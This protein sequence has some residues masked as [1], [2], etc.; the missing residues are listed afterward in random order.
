M[1]PDRRTGR[2]SDILGHRVYDDIGEPIGRI[3]DL[4]TEG[5]PDGTHRVTAAIVV[6]HHWGRL[7]GYERREVTGPW[8]LEHLARLILRRDSQRIPWHSLRLTPHPPR[9]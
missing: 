2:A 6:R 3:A 5:M 1:S 4:I 7:L 8:I 9:P